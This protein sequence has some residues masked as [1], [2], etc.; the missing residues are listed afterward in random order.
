MKA[1]LLTVLA[2]ALMTSGAL[3]GPPILCHPLDIAK[4]KSIPMGSGSMECSSGLGPAKA[5]DEAVAILKSESSPLVRMETLR[6]AT[7][8]VN[9]DQPLA[10]SLFARVMALSLDAQTSKDDQRAAAALFDAGFLA[11]CYHEMSID[12]GFKAGEADG[13][14]G[15]AWI[16]SAIDKLP[17][18]APERAEMEFGAA[19]AAHPMEHN[20]PNVRAIYD[21]HLKCAA[22]GAKEGSL[23]AANIK[24]HHA[25]WDQYLNKDDSKK[26]TK[27]AERK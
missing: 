9:K 14:P 1:R 13:I 6:R 10:K 20:S 12:L 23:L 4:A 8:Y 21:A 16:K 25:R 19:L 7:V 26:D 18:S 15:Y 3:A 5:A 11:A 22:D 27:T 2:F 24:A 17:T